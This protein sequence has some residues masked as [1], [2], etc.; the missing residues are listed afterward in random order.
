MTENNPEI[1]K[2]TLVDENGDEALFEVL[3]TFHSEE[4]D[5]DYILLVPDGVEE[6]E[7]VDVQAYIFKPDENG[8]AT[9]DDLIPI[10][11]DAEWDMV[12]EVLNTFLD[13][14]SNFN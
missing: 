3:F 14:D 7:Q 10:E 9:E 5:R 8:D 2:I 11:D 12:E 6:D 13:D 4:Y 1:D